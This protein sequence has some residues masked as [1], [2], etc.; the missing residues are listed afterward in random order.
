[1]HPKVS[2][3]PW[4]EAAS[5]VWTV[6]RQDEARVGQKNGITGRWTKRGTR[7]PAPKDQ[8][9]T[10]EDIYGAICPA[11]ALGAHA[12][13]ILDKA[14][15]HISAGLVA[16][17]NITHLPLCW[18]NAPSSTRSKTSGSSCVTTGCRT[19][20]TNPTKTSSIMAAS[21]ATTSRPA[22][23]HHVHRTAPMGPWVTVSESCYKARS[24]TN[25]SNVVFPQS[26]PTNGLYHLVSP[27][28]SNRKDHA[29]LC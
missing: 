23:A 2:H 25:S 17:A 22:L 24:V 3:R 6:W 15:W 19:A 8:H 4:I 21:P 29:L 13:L 7:P 28:L 16:P 26:K 5:P 27:I 11:V 10:S 1:M 14:S 18:R 20:S 9:S 12:V